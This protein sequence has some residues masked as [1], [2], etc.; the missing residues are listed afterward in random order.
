MENDA[1]DLDQHNSE[2]S[3]IVY[4]DTIRKRRNLLDG[5]LSSYRHDRMKRK[6]PIDDQMLS[7]LKEDLSIKKRLIE[8]MDSFDKE[9]CENMKLQTT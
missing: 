1:D 2:A 4:D 3:S 6:L 5:K 7:C 8:Q 9:Y